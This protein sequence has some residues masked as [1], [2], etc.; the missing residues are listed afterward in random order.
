M[1]QKRKPVTDEQRCTHAELGFVEYKSADGL[2][3]FMLREDYRK[4]LA[5]GLVKPTGPDA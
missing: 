2:H 1:K 4:A 3:G 5:R